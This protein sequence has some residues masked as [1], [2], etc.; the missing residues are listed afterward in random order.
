MNGHNATGGDQRQYYG[1][2][3]YWAEEQALGAQ[4]YVSY[5]ATA[6]TIGG[7]A[8]PATNNP[9]AWIANQWVS[10][11]P[12]EYD[13]VNGTSDF[14]SSTNNPNYNSTS[15]TNPNGAPAYVVA[16][17]GPASYTGAPW[18]IHFTTTTAQDAQGQYVVLSVGLVAQDSSLVISLNG[19]SETWS[20]NN[21]SPDDPMVRS[22]DAGFYQ[23][24]AF[25]F[26][27]TDLEKVGTDNEFT[28]G[29]SDHADGVMYDALRMEIT[30][31]SA[32]PT[33][34]GWHDYTYINGSTQTAQNDA[35]SLV[36]DNVIT[37]EPSSMAVLAMGGL[38]L[39]RRRRFVAQVR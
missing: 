6:T 2:Y 33:T 29:L 7:V 9:N 34:T 16:A 5:N 15:S 4:G 20:Y 23:W 11:N 19:H 18:Q 3:N 27:T 36:A 32:N 1:A 28:L 38:L 13:S 21:F 14:Y 17:G 26:P 25:Q 35:D 10:F 30:N 12:G 31:T 24:A 37:P 22:G 39:G 8:E